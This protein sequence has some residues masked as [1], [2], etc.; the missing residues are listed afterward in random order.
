MTEIK[1]PSSTRRKAN[2]TSHIDRLLPP[3]LTDLLAYDI[4]I[5][6]QA[7]CIINIWGY[8]FF[9]HLH[10]TMAFHSFCL[11]LYLSIYEGY[12]LDRKNRPATGPRKGKPRGIKKAPGRNSKV[13]SWV[14]CWV[15]LFLV[16]FVSVWLGRIRV[17]QGSICLLTVAFAHGCYLH[18]SWKTV[19]I[20][21]KVSI[22]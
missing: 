14:W 1:L 13:V 9:L 3:F 22:C 8:V 18:L 5:I 19:A 20:C 2:Y 12:K 11:Q 15:H 21:L 6:Q 17:P 4:P 7:W 16:W 10:F